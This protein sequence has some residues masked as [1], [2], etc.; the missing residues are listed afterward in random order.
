[1]SNASGSEKGST[2]DSPIG[3]VGV[4]LPLP[5]RPSSTDQ[6][7]NAAQLPTPKSTIGSSIKL[8]TGNSASP[9]TSSSGNG[10]AKRPFAIPPLPPQPAVE[11]LVAAYVDFVGVTAPI[12]H[13]PTLG[14][15]LIKI[16]EGGNDVEQ[17]DVFIVMMMLG[18]SVSGVRV[19]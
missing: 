7:H 18:E 15:Q 11:R 14:K 10:K 13:V 12:I 1:M 2:T 19:V 9:H 6:T 4:D 16:R 5:E 17:S 3:V 8:A